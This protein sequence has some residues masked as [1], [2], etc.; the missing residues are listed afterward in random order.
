MDP[1]PP[2][3][4]N[5]SAG[6]PSG[7]PSESRQQR[8]CF[9]VDSQNLF[10]AARDAAGRNL[11]YRRLL[12]LAVRGRR[13]QSATAYVVERDGESNA[14]GFITRIS[15]LGYRVRRRKLRIHRVDDRG[16]T[17]LE[18]DWD[19]GI[20]ADIVRALDHCDVIVLGSGDGDFVPM[21]ELAQQRGL[22]V[23]VLA[24]REAA[25]QDLIDL[26]DRFVD[27]GTVA[28]VL[29]PGGREDGG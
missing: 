10:Y 6:E 12:E 17:V 5:D 18:G 7:A 14:H 1:L 8:A 25:A 20:A 28:D 9:F 23:E 22:R 3:G 4:G 15:S 26:A 19:M 16:R 21:L 11:D 29:L 13:L 2:A 27:L 24:F